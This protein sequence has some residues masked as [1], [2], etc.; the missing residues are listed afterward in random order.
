[1][2]ITI[3]ALTVFANTAAITRTEKA[4]A[5][6]KTA[7]R[8][9]KQV[10]LFQSEHLGY[11]IIVTLS[12]QSLSRSSMTNHGMNTEPIDVIS[13]SGRKG[14]ERPTTFILHGLRIDV[15][16]ILDYWLEEGFKDR[17]L[18]RFFKIRGS[19]GN[20]HRLYHDEHTLEWYYVF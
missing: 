18:K 16:E 19:D 12:L 20:T 15:L 11:I 9:K 7:M 14:Y 6:K 1:M 13:Y 4:A 17:M 5:P 8:R 10:R 2:H 3:A